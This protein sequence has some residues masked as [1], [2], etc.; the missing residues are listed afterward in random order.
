MTDLSMRVST[1]VPQTMQADDRLVLVLMDG[2][3]GTICQHAHSNVHP[4]VM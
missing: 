4:D 1:S 2:S 3:G